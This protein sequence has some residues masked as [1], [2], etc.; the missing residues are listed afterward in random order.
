[1]WFVIHILAEQYKSRSLIWSLSV[2]ETKIS[3]NRYRFGMVWLVLTPLFNVATYWVVFG[4]GIRNGAPVDDV[5]FLAWMLCGLIP[6]N[7]L[8]SGIVGS[9][10][11]INK[12]LK[13]VVKMNFPISTLPIVSIVTEVITFLVMLLILI[14]ILLFNGIFPT[15]YWV[16]IIYYLF[17]SICLLFSIGL[18]FSSIIIVFRDF[19]QILMSALKMLFYL[20][21]ILWETST[22]PI[23]FVFLLKLNP[24][25]YLVEGFRNSF[26]GQEWFFEDLAYTIYFWAFTCLLLIIGSYMHTRLKSK[27]VDYA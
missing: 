1:M 3:F 12:R 6:W 8:S 20:T 14:V 5:P 17:A 27:F 18:L 7:F 10:N 23:Q 22:L 11:S 19:Q 24:L 2:Y 16:Q 15:V 26:V 25:Y 21:P 9:S 13:T 4:L